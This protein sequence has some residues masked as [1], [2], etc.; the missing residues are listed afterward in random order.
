MGQVEMSPGE[1]RYR[2]YQRRRREIV[3]R[4]DAGESAKS[5]GD[6]LGMSARNVNNHAYRERKAMRERTGAEG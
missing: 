2:K 4:L 1:K 5:I 6:S 3:R